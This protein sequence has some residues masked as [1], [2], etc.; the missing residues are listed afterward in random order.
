MKKKICTT[1][2]TRGTA[3]NTPYPE[4]T[5]P[6]G[7]CSVSVGEAMFLVL[8][9]ITKSEALELGSS[10]PGGEKAIYGILKDAEVWEAWLESYLR[11][12]DF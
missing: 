2:V 8:F 9:Q 11:G 3:V 12:T 1:L 5:E 10:T 6:S 4:Q 7:N